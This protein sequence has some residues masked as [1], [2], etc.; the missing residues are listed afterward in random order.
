VDSLLRKQIV[1]KVKKHLSK[2]VPY[3]KDG[4]TSKDIQTALNCCRNKSYVLLHE[5]MK[6]KEITTTNVPH[7]DLMGR[8]VI[9]TC[10]K[11]VK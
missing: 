9:R 6:N 7:C 1:K 3:S 11:F 10:Y 5:W 2:G 4:F 8:S